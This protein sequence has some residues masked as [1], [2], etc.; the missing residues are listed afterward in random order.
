MV[1]KNPQIS[2]FKMKLFAL[3][4]QLFVM[5]MYAVII[6][7]DMSTAEGLDILNCLSINF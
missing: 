7:R 6:V 2:N 5:M 4:I 1:P 3:T